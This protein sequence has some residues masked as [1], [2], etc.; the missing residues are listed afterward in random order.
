MDTTLDSKLDNRTSSTLDESLEQSLE[1]SLDTTPPSM[2]HRPMGVWAQIRAAIFQPEY[3]FRSLAHEP[4][5][6]RQWL[7]A[8]IL[9]LALVGFS[10]IRHAELTAANANGGIPADMGGVPMDGG[11]MGGDPR[12]GGMP[13]GVP[14]DPGMNPGMG[15]GAPTGAT[16]D[17]A[18]TWSTA[19]VAAAGILLAWIIQAVLLCE[20]SMMN[21]YAPKLGRNFRIAVWASVPLGLMAG[22]QLIYFAAGGKVGQPGIVGLLPLWEN[23]ANLEPSVQLVLRSLASQTTIFWL[24]NLLLLYFG[25]RFT[26]S[27]KRWAVLI[28]LTAWVVLLVAAPI[29]TGAIAIEPV[30]IDPAAGGMPQDGSVPVDMPAPID[31]QPVDGQPIDGQPI[32]GQPAG[33]QGGIGQ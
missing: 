3:F 2:R 12:Q 24:W 14:M 17:V 9:I 11:M 27:G 23:Y 26:L 13:G 25:A 1:E 31:G 30:T 10:A 29:A 5:Q 28:V 33:E 20:V 6:A 8:A 15:G 32:D 19:M 4:A 16:T 18:E 7:W 22:L 21:G